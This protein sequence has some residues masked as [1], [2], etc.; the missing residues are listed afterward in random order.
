MIIKKKTYN[1]DI[2]IDHNNDVFGV[3]TFSRNY[4]IRFLSRPDFTDF[5][6]S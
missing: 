5:N 6:T 4:N 2:I 3:L 1:N